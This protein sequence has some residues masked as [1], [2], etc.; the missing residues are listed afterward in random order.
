[1]KRIAAIALGIT[2]GVSSFGLCVSEVS[3]LIQKNAPIAEEEVIAPL[4]EPTESAH[5]ADNYLGADFSGGQ[6]SYIINEPIAGTVNTFECWIR[7]QKNAYNSANKSVIFGNWSN[8]NAANTNKIYTNWEVLENGRVAANWLGQTV[9]FYNTDVRTGEWVHVAIV[10]DTEDKTFKLYLNGELDEISN[11]YIA[12][13]VPTTRD[14]QLDSHRIGNAIYETDA[15]RKKCF[16]GEIGQITCYWSTRD[17]QEVKDDY[18]HSATISAQ[19]RD[20]DLILNYRIQL[21]ERY[22]YDTSANCNDATF[23]S[24]DYYYSDPLYDVQDYSFSVVGDVQEWARSYPASINSVVNWALEHKEDRKIANISFLGDLTDGY[25]SDSEDTIRYMWRNVSTPLMGI[26][27]RLALNVIPGNHDYKSDSLYRDL[28]I[29]NEYFKYDEISSRSNFGGAFEVGQSQNYW[30]RQVID[31]IPYLFLM[32]EMGCPPDAMEWFTQVIEAHPNHRV[33]VMTHAF[34]NGNGDMYYDEQY[35]SPV[36]YYERRGYPATGVYTMWEEYLAKYDNLFMILCGHSGRDTIAYR[37]LVGEKGNTVMVFRI[38]PS[39]IA[40]FSFDPLMALFQFNESTQTLYLN[41]FST[42]KN[43]LY[44]TQNQM[45][46]SYYGYTKF[47]KEYY[48]GVIV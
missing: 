15:Q 18:D 24:N 14:Y 22:L 44:N 10:R 34:L 28:T 9:R 12:Q 7:M 4:P 37:E 26:G 41:Y 40:N 8:G 6:C 46:I 11:V 1:M 19:T 42:D 21:G 35:L 38:D 16:N 25:G 39:F 47:T 23:L 13:D 3:A 30:T 5:L 29:F 32:L 33:V 27:D 2:V 48:K 20:N 17:A 45:I 36:W 43:M 31:G